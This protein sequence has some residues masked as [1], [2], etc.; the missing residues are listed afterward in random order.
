MRCRVCSGL[1]RHRD[2]RGRAR[3]VAP[4]A[5]RQ[6]PPRT[7]AITFDDLPGAS[8]VRGDV[9]FFD[10]V[11][12]D[13]IAALL[14]HAVP[15]IGFVNESKL[16]YSGQTDPARVALLKQWL[17]A[18]FELGN[19]TYAHLDLHIVPVEDFTR[20]ILRGE[21]VTRKL[22]AEVGKRPR[23]FRHPFLHTGRDAATRSAIDVFLGKHGYRVAPV[24]IDNYDYMF[25]RAYDR[26]IDAGNG[27]DA[28]Q[29]G[30]SYI[31]YMTR[32]V[33]YYEQQ[34][35]AIL[36][37]ELA[38]VL[39]LHV[40]ALNARTFDALARMFSARGYAFVPLD[41]A[42]GG[43]APTSHATSSLVREASRGCIAGR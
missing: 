3:I 11:N 19:H 32:V 29:I 8:P 14:R 12:R 10:S 7:V 9:E 24:T 15:A 42:H 13:L 25:A 30:N 21:V 6:P 33:A 17:D 35:T 31:D 43:S 28:Q 5:A 2:T 34:S 1:P 27:A 4:T 38:Q 16:A 39:L 41:R 20:D 26:A 40:N 36:G 18:G 23:Y 22:Q 37:R